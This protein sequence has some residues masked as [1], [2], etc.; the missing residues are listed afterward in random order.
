[1][2]KYND[3]RSRAAELLKTRG[4]YDQSLNEM[5]LTSMIEELSIY[6]IE[7][8]HQNASLIE[9]QNELRATKERYAD[10][11]NKAPIGYVILDASHV[12]REINDT[13]CQM[14]HA[15]SRDLVNVKFTRLVDPNYQDAFYFCF[16]MS[17]THLSS[18][19]CDIRC[20]TM[21]DGRFYARLIIIPEAANDRG[22]GLFRMAIMDISSEKELEVRLLAETE[23]AKKSDQLKS[24][25]LA[26][27]SH[28]IRTPLN[29]IL[30]FASL[31]VESQCDPQDV[32][33]FSEIIFKGG[34]RL[35][36]LINNILDISKIES[37]N[38]SLSISE[39]NPSQLVDEVMVLFQVKA[40]EKG[41]SLLAK[42][43]TVEDGLKFLSDSAKI[44]Q[45][46]AN[47]VSN[48]IKFTSR[49]SIEIGFTRNNDYFEFSVSDTGSGIPEEDQPLIFSRFY[50]VEHTAVDKGQGSG[51]GL[52]L[53]K[54]LVE[55][56]Q[57]CISFESVA[58][59]GSVF[60]F[61]IPSI[62]RKEIYNEPVKE[63]VQAPLLN[64][65]EMLNLLL[66]EDEEDSIEYMSLLLKSLRV[67]FK[68]A[69]N[70]AEAVAMVKAH[71]GINMVFMDIRLP[72][73]NGYEAIG[74]IRSIR[75]DMRIVALTAF[76]LE[77]DRRKAFETGCDDFVSKP[78][79]RADLLKVMSKTERQITGSEN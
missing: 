47:L 29:A 57:G 8:E 78:V 38:M 45:V 62:D 34:N 33:R 54:G 12:I 67:S 68:L 42:V 64:M 32:W 5:D 66:V 58:G 27:M 61:S 55:L 18:S 13:A 9:A 60:R 73:M 50:Q 25:F 35:L 49:G 20:K 22:P 28:E 6:Q 75:P 77:S 44:N 7:L 43:D 40:R 36:M 70:G 23:K 65:G 69:R 2:D 10:L 11:F 14:L 53:S 37:G 51:L 15:D 41:I 76:A 79:S 24:A 52:S 63:V 74:R 56:L 16:R 39:C 3:L 26:N 72:V 4:S 46:L 59:Q 17:G 30:G 48:A 71:P 31:L 1:M 19:T 21:H